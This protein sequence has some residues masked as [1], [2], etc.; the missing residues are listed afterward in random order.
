MIRAAVCGLLSS[1]LVG[2]SQPALAL[3]PAVFYQGVQRLQDRLRQETLAQDPSRP[4]EMYLRPG[5]QSR[6]WL[7]QPQQARATVLFFHAPGAGPWQAE[8]FCP[9][10]AAAGFHCYAPRLPGHGWIR[11]DGSQG[12]LIPDY[13]QRAQYGEFLAQVHADVLALQA[14]VYALGLSG[15]ANLA[16]SLALGQEQDAVPRIVAIAP[17]LGPEP[18]DAFGWQ[19]LAATQPLFPGLLAG[20]PAYKGAT[21]PEPISLDQALTLYRL[22]REAVPLRASVQFFTFDGQAALSGLP[23]VRERIAALGGPARHG[24]YHQHEPMELNSLLPLITAFFSSGEPVWKE[25]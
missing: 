19:L 8:A 14:P 17:M 11:A 25:P 5:F 23:P 12:R 22:G 24:W 3:D 9:G 7:Q 16:L 1:L 6:L 2:L 20:L 18:G 4:A 15:G 21:G 10:L 13:A